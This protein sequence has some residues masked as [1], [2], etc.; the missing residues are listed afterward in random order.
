MRWNRATDKKPISRGARLEVQPLTHLDDDR[1]RGSLLLSLRLGGRVSTPPRDGSA[2]FVS[3]PDLECHGEAGS[4]RGGEGRRCL[5]PEGTI[6]RR[7]VRPAS[8]ARDARAARTRVSETR[9]C[10]EDVILTRVNDAV[11]ESARVR[12]TSRTKRTVTFPAGSA[13]SPAE[14]AIF[15]LRRAPARPSIRCASS[16]TSA[17]DACDGK[18]ESLRAHVVDGALLGMSGRSRDLH[19]ATRRVPLMGIKPARR[20]NTRRVV[21]RKILPKP[22]IYQQNIISL[23]YK[24]S[25]VVF[26]VTK[27]IV[28]DD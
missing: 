7:N 2:K 8:G 23:W 1:V 19:T 9:S 14:V 25:H 6:S 3:Q 15:P 4:V 10:E 27:I 18:L 28:L 5:H 21:T 13:F 26:V 20:G 12:R 16:E 24:F 22:K 17:M 11:I